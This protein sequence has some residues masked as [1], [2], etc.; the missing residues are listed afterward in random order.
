MGEKTPVFKSRM[1]ARVF[2]WLDLN[3]NVIRWG[4]EIIDIPYLFQVDGRM[5]TYITDIY[6]EIRGNNSKVNRYI[7]EVKP[8]KETLPPKPANNSPKSK[9]RYQREMFVYIK[10]SDK[11][12]A[13]R[14]FCDS[15]G[16]KFVEVTD[17]DIKTFTT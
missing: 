13:T 7:L 5:H 15:K 12:E 4:Y 17:E 14:R 1:E 2:R 11:W 6:C 10:N 8:V 16:I 3:A 9:A